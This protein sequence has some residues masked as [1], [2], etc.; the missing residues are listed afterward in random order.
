MR[1]R[2]SQQ[3]SVKKNEIQIN[4]IEN[5]KPNKK[6]IRRPFLAK[7]DIYSINFFDES[8]NIIYRLGIGNPFEI[9]IQH[10]GYTDKHRHS[11]IDLDDHIIESS[12]ITN[13]KLVI[14][15]ELNPT[16]IS[17]SKRGAL[18]SY[19]EVARIDVK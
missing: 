5:K 2:E 18:N 8:G 12:N 15:S 17:L 11:H 3:K 14:P 4:S 9:K 6:N 13:L 1:A 19:K 16:S 10:I 7:T